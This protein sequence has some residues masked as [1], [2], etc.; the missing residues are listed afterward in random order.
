MAEQIAFLL[1]CV[2]V[3]ATPSTVR[4]EGSQSPAD[5][6]EAR[7]AALSKT[8][9]EA[10]AHLKAIYEEG[11]Y[12]AASFRYRWA[13]DGDGY[14]RWEAAPKGKGRDLVRYDCASGERTVVIR[15]EGLTAPGKDEP[16][17]VE[18]YAFSPQCDRVLL[19]ARGR[20]P[21]GGRDDW[22]LDR[23]SGTLRVLVTGVDPQPARGRLSP[24]G[25]YLLYRKKNNLYVYGLETGASKAL[26]QDGAVD[27]IDY[28][29][30]GLGREGKSAWSADGRYLLLR[31]VDERAVPLR[32]VLDPVDPSYPKVRYVRFARVG[33]PIPSLRLGVADPETGKT[34]W[35][36]VPGK[37]GT[38]YL[39][40]VRWAGVR[41]EIVM[42]KRSRGRDARDFFIADPRTGEVSLLYRETDPAW[43]DSSRR[44]NLGLECLEEGRTFLLLSEKDGWRHAF[45]LRRDGAEP[46]LLTPGAF[47]MVERARVDET[48]GWF[49]YIASPANATQRYLYRVR[50]DGSGKTE[51]ITP[52]DRPGTHRYDI[53]PGC[54]W[55]VHTFST[56]D[57]PPVIELVSLPGHEAVRVLEDNHVLRE[58][59]ASLITRPTEFF[60]I[61]IEGGVVM[62]AMMLKPRDFD[63]GRKYPVFVHV[64]GEPH[65]QT[66]LDAWGTAH[67]LFHRMIA[68]L[69]YLVVSMDNRGTAAPK[70]A[71]WRRAVFGSLG[72]LSTKE[73]AQGLEALGRMRPYVDLSRVGIWGWSGGGSNT[74]NAM[75]RRP[76]LYRVGIAVAPKPQPRLYNAWFQEI[77]MRTPEENP[78]GYARSAPIN[79]AEGLKGD[80]LII[81][82]TGETNTHIQ[83]TEGLVDRLIA[84]GKRFDY[85]TYPNRDH[86]LWKGKGTAVH[87]RLLITRYLLEHLPP[88]SR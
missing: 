7:R 75:F 54:R 28:R 55:A 72:P 76:D 34:R 22:L 14:L 39:P 67:A 20:T 38:Y 74:L 59:T 81:H 68:D 24:D 45:R 25:R 53:A 69:G 44:E 82:G 36:A 21:A 40:W 26:T 56:Y 17:R 50:L 4:G 61:P 64:Y 70:G 6:F 73:Q 48:G 12:R 42:E 66:V 49:Y 8:L 85:M 19:H 10:E 43:I 3:G 63:P 51:R 33:A 88:G 84:L 80:L 86:G 71:A 77:Y 78:E 32:P 18:D 37:P 13:P 23:A 62:D 9:D 65:L 57:T 1:A 15:G 16:L 11:R 27:G 83:I 29:F 58:R 60:K 31:R 41:D 87:L 46:V 47:D 5:R 79:F 52:A 35:I 30:V 2:L